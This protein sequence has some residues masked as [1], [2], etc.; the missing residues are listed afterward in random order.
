MYSICKIDL[1]LKQTQ[2]DIWT[3]S[4]IFT[5]ATDCRNGLLPDRVL[6]LVLEYINIV[7]NIILNF[8]PSVEVLMCQLRTVKLYHNIIKLDLES[9]GSS[10]GID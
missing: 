9:I 4:S 10:L 6:T 3:L 1:D 7:A 8:P 2:H 5:L